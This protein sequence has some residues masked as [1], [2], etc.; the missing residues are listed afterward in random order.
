MLFDRHAVGPLQASHHIGLLLFCG[1]NREDCALVEHDSVL[2]Q[3]EGLHP[4][5]LVLCSIQ[6]SPGVRFVDLP[7]NAV[8]LN[9]G[10]IHKQLME[11]VISGSNSGG[12][13][14]ACFCELHLGGRNFKFP[15]YLVLWSFPLGNLEELLHFFEELLA[16]LGSHV[17]IRMEMLLAQYAIIYLN[18][19]QVHLCITRIIHQV[20]GELVAPW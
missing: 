10:V 14:C 8:P 16:F 15:C 7:N 3:L 2:K 9:L 12:V 13:Y 1:V 19:L 5:S 11:Q 17:E 20:T 6:R 18:P 4:Q